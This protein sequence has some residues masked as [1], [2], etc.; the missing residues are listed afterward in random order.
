M[1]SSLVDM[2][3]TRCDPDRVPRSDIVGGDQIVEKR[4]P[5]LRVTDLCYGLTT[6]SRSITNGGR[7]CRITCSTNSP[8]YSEH[9]V[10]G[11]TGPRSHGSNPHLS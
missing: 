9:E 10:N 1:A 5:T 8:T 4:Q 3:G 7:G 2:S 11:V 6:R